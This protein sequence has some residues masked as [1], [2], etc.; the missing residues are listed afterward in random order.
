VAV[1]KL[2]L[3]LTLRSGLLAM[4]SMAAQS[5]PLTGRLARWASDGFTSTVDRILSVNSAD[6]PID[7]FLLF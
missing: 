4:A 2:R 7:P 1:M 5:K 6:V 3:V